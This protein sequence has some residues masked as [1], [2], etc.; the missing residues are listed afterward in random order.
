MKKILLLTDYKGF[1]GSKRDDVPYRSGMDI[2]FIRDLFN[3][4][5]YEVILQN[6]SE[7]NFR[8]PSYR[9]MPCLYT[10]TEEPGLKYKSFVEDV[11]LGLELAG[12]RLIPPFKYLRATNNKVFM[13]I[14]RDLAQNSLLKNI[15]SHAFGSYEEFVKSVIPK[16]KTY[17]VKKAAG[18]KSRG[19]FLAK[20]PKKLNKLV[21]LV[22]RSSML[23]YELKDRLRKIKHKGYQ[24]DSGHLNKFLVQDYISGLDHDWKVL[25]YSHKYYVLKRKNRAHDFRAS[26]S[27][28]FE[29][30]EEV[31]KEV[32]EFAET[33]FKEFNLPVNSFD[34][35]IRDN[36][37]FLLEFQAVYFGT[38]TLV[39]SPFY[40]EKK[41]KDWKITYKKSK[42]EEEYVKSIVVYLTG[43]NENN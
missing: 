42:L 20:N 10:C 41:E 13:E 43:T 30:T 3:K 4:Q 15:R 35:A 24:P 39:K 38:T 7:V 12:A 29:F 14:L 16:D 6:F 33:L 32:L 23:L 40:Y 25:V 1:F 8:D 11:V 19:V 5:G 22:S 9:G 37:C 31:P 27:G 34:I 21:Q 36:E 18:A 17:V 2:E 28:N 26:G